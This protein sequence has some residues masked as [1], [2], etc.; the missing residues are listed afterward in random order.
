MRE[1]L[2]TA[3]TWQEIE[4]GGY[5]A[6]LDLFDRLAAEADGPVLE[7]GCGTGRVTLHLARR[8]HDMTGLDSDQEVL[9][10]LQARARNEQLEV[11]TVHADARACD[12]RHATYGLVL[13][14]MQLVQL[15]GGADGRRALLRGVRDHLSP[16]GRL[17]AAI[18]GS[19]VGGVASVATLPDFREING[20]VL[21]SLPT[22]VHAEA[23]QVVIERLRQRVSAH[24]QLTEELHQERLDEL[25][26]TEL[27]EE[28]LGAGF[29]PAGRVQLAESDGYV[30]STVV[31]LEARDA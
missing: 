11:A 23:G 21:S 8:G 5:G 10:E 29:E 24:G 15:M 6:D 28:A 31:L 13:A 3:A 4:C 22:R 1:P 14:P 25:S 9:R 18:I 26:A 19:A 20:C 27:E 16:G 30:G 2:A 17:A 12:L 7:L